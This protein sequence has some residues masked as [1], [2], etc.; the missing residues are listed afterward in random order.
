MQAALSDSKRGRYKDYYYE[1]DNSDGA[2]NLPKL[3]LLNMF[4]KFRKSL[5]FYLAKEYYNIWS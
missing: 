1:N 2:K 5:S 3:Y 4:Y